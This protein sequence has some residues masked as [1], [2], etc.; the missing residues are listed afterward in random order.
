VKVA[1][2]APPWLP[3]PPAGYGGIE[4][5][6]HSLARHLAARRHEVHV[7]TVGES[8]V[9]LDQEGIRVHALFDRGHYDK[10]AGTLYDTLS[11]PVAHVLHALDE[12]ARHGDFDIIHD[13][14]GFVGPVACAHL[15]PRRFP[16]VLHTLHA[17]FTPRAAVSAGAPDNRRAYESLRETNGLWFNAIS[18]GQRHDAPVPLR[19][20]MLGVV[21]NGVELDDIPQ[22]QRDD[23]YFLTLARVCRDKNQGLAARICRDLGSRLI[24]AGAVSGT[25]TPEAVAARVTAL[26]IDP[27]VDHPDLRYFIEEVA[28]HLEPGRI[29]FLGNVD[30]TRKLDLV[31]GAHALLFPIDWEEPFGVAVI[32]ALACGTPV[33]AMRRGAMPELI[34]H[35]VNGFLADDATAFAHYMTRVDEIDPAA[36]RRSVE[37]RFSAHHM[38]EGYLTVYGEAIELSSAR[39]ATPRIATR[40]FLD[41]GHPAVHHGDAPEALEDL[42]VRDLQS[43]K[44][45]GHVRH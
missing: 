6:V 14:N 20:R 22:G 27:S 28:P 19:R 30:G 26:E 37:C 17:P 33:I 16:P 39:T 5:V 4:R 35:G 40:S 2:L 12:V 9:G 36:C 10:L 21:H 44:P 23:G 25:G 31:H 8:T 42:H 45:V 34:E 24:I 1:M 3:I 43:R 32:E 7:F 13:H 38:T 15:D 29:D 18:H 41:D 11:I